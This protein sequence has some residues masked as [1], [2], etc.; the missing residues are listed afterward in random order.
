MSA[1]AVILFVAGFALAVILIAVVIVDFRRMIIPD[2]LNL[3]LATS[4]FSFQL[5]ASRDGVASQV[6]FAVGVLAV[7]WA[8]RHGHFA[9]TGRIGLGLGDVKMLGAA[10]LWISP[11]LF[12]ILIFIASASALLFVGAQVIAIGPAAARLR[13]PFGPF[14]AL[15]LGCAWTLE[16]ILGWNLGMS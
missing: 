6:V 13:V 14:I 4:G 7:F 2:W 15:G 10:A 11:L 8:M 3:A 16:Q 12:P 9:I 5:F 1:P